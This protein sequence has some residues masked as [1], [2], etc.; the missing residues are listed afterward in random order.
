MAAERRVTRSLN[1]VAQTLR[2]SKVFSRVKEE[3]LDSGTD[4]ED[5]HLEQTRLSQEAISNLQVF[6]GPLH[7]PSFWE[8]EGSKKESSHP[9][10]LGQEWIKLEKDTTEEKMPVT[11]EDVAVN[12]TQQE[13]ECLDASQRAL[14]QGVMSETFKNLESVARIFLPKPDLIT[15]LEQE[16]RQRRVDLHHPN[17]QGLLSGGKKEEFQEPGQKLRDEGTSDDKKVSLVHRGTGQSPRSGRTSVFQ[18]SQAGP[19]FLC[20]ACGRCFS[21]SSYLHNHQF[22]HNPKQTNI[23]SQCGKLFWSPKALSY[24]RRKHHGERPFCCPLCD[25]TYCDASGLSRHRRVHLGYRP[26]SCPECGKCFRDKS[27]L[28]RHQKIH[29]NQEPVAGNQEHIVRVPGTAG[30]REPIVRRQRSIQAPVTRT[31]EPIFRNESPVTRTQARD[32]RSSCP[33]TR[34]SSSLVQPSRLKVFSCPHCPLTFSKKAYLAS[35][36]KVHLTEQLISCF[37]CG[38]SFSSSFWLAKHQQTHWKQKIYR[39]PI[40][41]LCFGDKE[42]LL[43]HWRRY[44]G[45]EQC[46]GSPHKC[47]VILG[48]RLG[49]FHDSP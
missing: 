22:V 31:Q 38:K 18:T 33:N 7:L 10:G 29:Q 19:P 27:E 30:F 1:S 12:F 9:W 49:C 23:C 26:H 47:W 8:V 42:D 41:D 15:K 48:Q 21:K 2:E 14:Y 44:K 35:H 28:K 17:R 46:L 4:K 6:V 16:E 25:K 13:W 3:N 24:H 5:S 43:N 32:S 34:F 45:K 20:H 37:H 40:C 39:C 11:F 36:Q